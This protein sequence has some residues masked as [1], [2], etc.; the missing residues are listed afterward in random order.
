M[1]ALVL[2]RRPTVNCFSYIFYSQ[3][4]FIY[5][6][7]HLVSFFEYNFQR[8]MYRQTEKPYLIVVFFLFPISGI[9]LSMDQWNVLRDHAD[10][11]DELVAN[12]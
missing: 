4:K 12:S 9:S 5:I 7:I 1:G 10:E 11:I 6:F 3:H 2:A 8:F